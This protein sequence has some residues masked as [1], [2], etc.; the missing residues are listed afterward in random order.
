MTLLLIKDLSLAET[1]D[2]Q[3]ARAVCGGVALDP[4]VSD[5]PSPTPGIAPG[6]CF[7]QQPLPPGF[8]AMPS[9]MTPFWAREAER[10]PDTNIVN[11]SQ[12]QSA[13]P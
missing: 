1:M 2:R 4:S 10:E 13:T 6:G 9:W 8:A 12:H 3:A 5:T 11:L 7:P